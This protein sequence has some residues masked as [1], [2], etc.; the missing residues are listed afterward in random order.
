VFVFVSHSSSATN[1][2]PTVK[3][4]QVGRKTLEP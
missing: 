4:E 2:T 3:S 1:K